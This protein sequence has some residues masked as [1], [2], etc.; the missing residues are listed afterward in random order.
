MKLEKK[1]KQLEEREKYERKID[2]MDIETIETLL[3]LYH[4]IDRIR[5]A[6]F[7]IGL[8]WIVVILLC[9]NIARNGEDTIP[10]KIVRFTILFVSNAAY[11]RTV[12]N[13][14]KEVK[15]I[16]EEIETKYDE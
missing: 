2:R 10:A 4:E 8:L 1:I 14:R 5:I 12:G 6:Q 3:A 15:H 16:A 11:F 13:A 7:L 9:L